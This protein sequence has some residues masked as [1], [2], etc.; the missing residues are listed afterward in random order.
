MHGEKVTSEK[1]ITKQQIRLQV[2]SRLLSLAEV[3]SL[4]LL[5]EVVEGVVLL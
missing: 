2:P 4:C 5:S 3:F 1:K